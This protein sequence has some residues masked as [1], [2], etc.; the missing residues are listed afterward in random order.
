MEYTGGRTKDTIVQW[1]LKK[2]GPP[3]TLATCEHLKSKVRD[4]KYAIVYFGSEDESLYNDV[5][6]PA[7]DSE[8]KIPFLHTTEADCAQTLASVSAPALVLFRNFDEKVTPYTGE[9]DKDTF[10]NFINP[11]LVPTLF[12]FTEDEIEAV[13]GKQQNTL[14]L[15]RDAKDDDEA[16]VKA[17]AQAASDHRGKMLFSFSD[18][19]HD[20]QEKL[21]EFMGVEESELPTLRAINPSKMTKYKF[22][23]SIKEI[24]SATVG[25]FV[26]GVNDGT[27][28][29]H[30]KSAPV[31]EDNT[32]PVTVIVGSEFD[33]IVNDPTKDVFVKFYAPWCGHCKKLAP[34]WEE[35]GEKYKDNKDLIIAKFDATANEAD[36][37][38][39]RGYPTLIFYPK[40][41]KSGVN[42]D[43]DRDIEGF[44][45][46]LAEK[47]T[48][49]TGA[50][51]AAKDD[52]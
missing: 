16:Y 13:F 5:H 10:L 38:N 21:A 44:S 43:G 41:N 4:E 35:L 47:A 11:L 24:S 31:P 45:K 12:K 40:D 18:K 26:A 20:I 3:S 29:P 23:G 15:F 9:K 49:L 39:I 37:V 28:T 42:Y 50:G 17:Y 1:V 7:A 14:I 52:L 27:A 34:V 48:S 46:W 36:G 32:G 51:E 22:P 2:S 30:L 33:K 8:D 25:D 6:V 19:T